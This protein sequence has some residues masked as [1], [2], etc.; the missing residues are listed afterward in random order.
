MSRRSLRAASGL[1]RPSE[2]ESQAFLT[3]RS[4]IYLDDA[5]RFKPRSLDLQGGDLHDATTYQRP[6]GNLHQSPESEDWC[7]PP[8]VSVDGLLQHPYAFESSL[9]Y[10]MIEQTIRAEAAPGPD[11]DDNGAGLD[12]PPHGC[13]CYVS[14]YFTSRRR[15]LESRALPTF[16]S[17][18]YLMTCCGLTSQSACE[19]EISP[20]QRCTKD[21]KATAPIAG[22]RGLGP[23][24]S[25]QR[26][27]IP[28]IPS[29][30]CNNFGHE[31]VVF[32]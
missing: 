22:T 29:C 3:S 11:G 1:R 15:P 24:V 17:T 31:S 23:Y 7:C 13:F 8:R 25:H 32:S 10:N 28:S 9:G 19:R 14:T 12:P 20:M 2:S 21:P 5:C 18:I 26:R 4:T 16:P 30:P 27:R 6:E